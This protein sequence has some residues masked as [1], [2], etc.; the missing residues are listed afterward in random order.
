MATTKAGFKTINLTK[1]FDKMDRLRC[2]EPM[3]WYYQCVNR[4][5]GHLAGR[6]RDKYEEHLARMSPEQVRDFR[7]YINTDLDNLSI[8]FYLQRAAW[9]KECYQKDEAGKEA[10]EEHK[11][12]ALEDPSR[13]PCQMKGGF[14]RI[15]DSGEELDYTY[16]QFLGE[17]LPIFVA[18]HNHLASI[19][20]AL[21]N[22]YYYAT[23]VPFSSFTPTG[24]T[25]ILHMSKELE[26]LMLG[27]LVAT[28]LQRR[29]EWQTDLV[30]YLAS[31]RSDCYRFLETIPRYYQNHR[32][33]LVVFP[34]DPVPE[35]V[36]PYRVPEDVD[37]YR[38]RARLNPLPLTCA[39]WSAGAYLDFLDTYQNIVH[40]LMA[41]I[42][43]SIRLYSV[44]Y[45]VPRRYLRLI[46]PM[47]P[48]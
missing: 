5:I 29:H 16:E 4:S 34:I 22:L 3:V 46:S 48:H 11:K 37:P 31:C 12:E 38:G 47:Q 26:R 32:M 1:I 15:A 19:N 20:R 21:G 35:N 14:A 30:S 25:E 8:E 13:H 44:W 17:T 43:W 6:E 42:V 2:L 23:E 28:H 33:R 40:H 18:I 10:K 45:F 7:R 41:V 36:D 27:L 9:A 39:P 24:K